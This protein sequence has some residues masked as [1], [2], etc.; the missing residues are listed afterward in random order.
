MSNI[1][2]YF[3]LET[4]EY[5]EPKH[6]NIFRTNTPNDQLK[7]Q[8]IKS[9][10]VDWKGDFR[11][12]FKTKIKEGDMDYVWE[13]V[14]DEKQVVP[15]FGG[16][17]Y[18]KAVRTGFKQFFEIKSREKEFS[19]QSNKLD[20]PIIKK[21][22]ITGAPIVSTPRAKP[23]V[24]YTKEEEVMFSE[25]EKIT[26]FNATELRAMFQKF[27]KETPSLEINK[28]GFVK[29][30]KGMGIEDEFLQDLIF[31]KFDTDKS[32]SVDF[33]E[34]MQGLSVMTRG[35]P[36]EKLKSAFEIIYKNL[37]LLYK[38][39]GWLHNYFFWQDLYR[40]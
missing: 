6:P 28:D 13:D 10:F 18:F 27:K 7:L 23:G 16:E 40:Y 20:S 32:G 21:R 12:Y 11:F 9:R 38:V 14:T 15:N 39:Q 8:D 3:I 17:I 24:T 1:V 5:E 19:G 34:F 35:T 36:E 31:N 25:L 30:T 22:P 2:K 33:R 26:H 4:D 37:V 29:V